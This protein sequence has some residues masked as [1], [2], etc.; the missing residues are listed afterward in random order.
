[1]ACI[2]EANEAIVHLVKGGI[3]ELITTMNKQLQF[4]AQG[5]PASA[6]GPPGLPTVQVIVLLLLLPLGSPI[7][8]RPGTADPN[9]APVLLN[10][11][12]A[13]DQL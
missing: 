9:P 7:Q 1:M 6:L 5:Q 3:S 8:W 2:R 10:T 11:H 13:I 12:T 4:V